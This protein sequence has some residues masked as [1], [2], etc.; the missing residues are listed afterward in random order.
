LELGVRTQFRLAWAAACAAAIP[1]LCLADDAAMPVRKPGWWELNM[2]TRGPTPS[3]IRQTARLCTDATV[4]QVQTPVGIRTGR[5]CPPIQVARTADGWTVQATCAVGPTTIA[6]QGRASGD[7]NSSYHVE[8]TTQLTPA[9]MPQ[10]A[11][12]Q[13][14]L[15][16]KWLGACPAGKAPGDVETTADPNAAPQAR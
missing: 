4:D 2:T 8:L 9:P 12:I 6:T 7:F 16:A 5:N 3:P 10:A 14:V 1:V 11:E 15:D 13:T